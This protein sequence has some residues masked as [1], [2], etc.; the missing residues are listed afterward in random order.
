MANWIELT[1]NEDWQT[2]LQTSDTKPVVLLKHSTTCPISANAWRECQTYLKK[3]ATEGAAFYMVKVIE[4]RALSLQIGED[5]NV[6]HKSPQLILVKNREAKW[7]TSHY[8]ITRDNLRSA[9]A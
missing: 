5:L 4:S 9:L 3:E 7:T 6:K 1:T 2:A 8:D